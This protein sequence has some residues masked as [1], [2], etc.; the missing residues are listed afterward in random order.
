MALRRRARGICLVLMDCDGVLT[1]GRIT[2]LSGGREAKSFNSKDGVGMRL[3]HSL[4]LEVGIVTGRR[5]E[6][7][8]RRGRELG[9]KEIHQ[10]IWDKLSL[11]ESLLRRKE[12]TF[13]QLCFIGD[14]IVDLPVLQRS[15]L[16]VAPADAH[17]EVRRRVHWVT[18]RGGGAGAVREVL[19]LLLDSQGL[20]GK[21]MERFL[22]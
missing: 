12:L 7:V 3:A 9:L 19:D 20:S 15:G 10:K 17:P 18:R 2:F 13:S 4:G 14:D 8:R 11:I 5:S 6:A 16:A 1:D 22:A 21:L